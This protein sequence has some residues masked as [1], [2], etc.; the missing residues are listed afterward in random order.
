MAAALALLRSAIASGVLGGL[1]DQG[2]LEVLH[3]LELLTRAAALSVRVQVDF[4]TS[5]IARQVQDGVAPSRAGAAVAGDLALARM[6]TPTMSSRE[7]TSA[8]ALTGEM[9]HTLAA[10]Q[11]GV[12]SGFQA[13][14]VTMFV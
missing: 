6:S 4:R 11:D 7:L 1:D 3:D 14:L 2:R 10:L 8:R 9:P 13:E 12:I 5:Q